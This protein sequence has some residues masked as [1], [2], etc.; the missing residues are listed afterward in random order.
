MARR[1]SRRKEVRRRDFGANLRLPPVSPVPYSPIDLSLARPVTLMQSRRVA[2]AKRKVLPSRAIVR[3]PTYSYVTPK[4]SK[5]YISAVSK[6]TSSVLPVKLSKSEMKSIGI[7]SSRHERKEV[8]FAS[9]NAGKRGQKKPV[10][11]SK[12]KVKC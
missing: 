12:S 9:G 4:Y 7:C 11:T 3:E 5:S 10:W 1:S 2:S 8:M 6:L